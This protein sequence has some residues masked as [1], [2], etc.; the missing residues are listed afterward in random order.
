V[1]SEEERKEEIIGGWRISAGKAEEP[2]EEVGEEDAGKSRGGL[3]NKRGC[4]LMLPR[5]LRRPANL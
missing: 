3:T 4:S 2:E 1:G 5:L